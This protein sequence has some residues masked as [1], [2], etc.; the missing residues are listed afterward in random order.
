MQKKKDS[1]GVV[2]YKLIVYGFAV[3]GLFHAIKHF[4]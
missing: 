4:L 3:Y 1:W 2:V